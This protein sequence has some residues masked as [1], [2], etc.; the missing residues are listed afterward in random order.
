[1]SSS[2][3]ADLKAQMTNVNN[4]VSSI[5]TVCHQTEFH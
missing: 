2:E 3:L 1:M 4:L 5:L